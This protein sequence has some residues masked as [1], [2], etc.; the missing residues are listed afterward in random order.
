MTFADVSNGNQHHEEGE[1]GMFLEMGINRLARDLFLLTAVYALFIVM[2]MSAAMRFAADQS[3][4]KEAQVV[5]DPPSVPQG[6]LLSLH[7]RK[8]GRIRVGEETVNT[9]LEAG[10]L[11]RR[12]IAGKPALRRARVILNIWR[13]TPSILTSD[14]TT[15]LAEAG[16]D[17]ERFYLRFTEK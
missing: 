17:E 15:A 11:V 16:L 8:D 4:A 10:D 7:L 3:W 2:F 13:D 1:S 14:V 12:L 5:D 6:L 9:P